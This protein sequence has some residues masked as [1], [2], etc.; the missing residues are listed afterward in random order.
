MEFSF[1]RVTFMRAKEREK[2]LSLFPF[3]LLFS[4]VNAVAGNVKTRERFTRGGSL[5][6][7]HIPRES[8][9]WTNKL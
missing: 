2:I 9:L 1:H 8:E 3:R 5:E 6:N 4:L 7:F